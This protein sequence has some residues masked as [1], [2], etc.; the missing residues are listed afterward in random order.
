MLDYVHYI[1]LLLP[2]VYLLIWLKTLYQKA[3]KADFREPPAYYFRQLVYVS[4][5]FGVATLI[6]KKLYLPLVSPLV[7]E[8]FG[9]DG[10]RL[11]VYPATLALAAFVH[12]RLNPTELDIKRRQD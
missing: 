12:T 10:F 6:E 7:E 11:L 2:V 4:V 8:N 5:L 3:S 9:F 1:W